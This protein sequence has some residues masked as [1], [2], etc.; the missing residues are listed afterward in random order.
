MEKKSA[1]YLFLATI[2]IGLL[3]QA[4]PY[5]NL[6]ELALT[7]IGTGWNLLFAFVAGYCFV[8]RD[9]LMQ[10]KHFSFK[11]LIWGVPL[12]LITG[13][14]FSSLYSAIFGQAT[15]NSIGETITLQ[16]VFVQVPFMLMGEELLSTNI[17]I[18]LQKRGLSFLW[19]SV[20]CS[21]LFALWHI[22]AYGFHP[23]QLLATLAPA[24][25]ALNYIWK[26]SNSVWVSWICHFIYDSLGFIMFFTK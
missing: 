7:I 17:L 12:V 2:A 6:P 21:I 22:P 4:L 5:M 20:I 13:L 1:N 19:A 18:A 3:Y 8:K 10:F 16:M 24:R 14:F 11:I 9:F 25:L 15:T 26:K 23:I